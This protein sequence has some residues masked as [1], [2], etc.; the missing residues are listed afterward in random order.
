M[1]SVFNFSKRPFSIKKFG[2]NQNVTLNHAFTS[3][4]KLK[5]SKWL[6]SDGAGVHRVEIGHGKDRPSFGGEV[7]ADQL[8]F[9]QNDEATRNVAFTDNQIVDKFW[10]QVEN[11]VLEK[12]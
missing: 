1:L 12:K 8:F 4:R 5:Y 7:N 9:R 3:L 2:Q 6:P 10:S 11:G